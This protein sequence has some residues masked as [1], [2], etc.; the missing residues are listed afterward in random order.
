MAINFKDKPAPFCIENCPCMKLE[1]AEEQAYYSNNENITSQ[2]TLFCVNEK[3]C[4]MWYELSTCTELKPEKSW[5]D[6]AGAFDELKLA[7]GKAAP[8]PTPPH[9][10][11]IP[12]YRAY[13]KVWEGWM[14]NHDRRIEDATCSKCGYRHKTVYGSLSKLSTECPA[15]KS[16]MF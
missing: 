9:R 8:Q 3:I 4:R 15:C 2:T 7:F 10:H 14:G 11:H 16:K 13:W 1:I 5:P 6:A 12:S